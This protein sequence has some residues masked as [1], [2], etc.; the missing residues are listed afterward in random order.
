MSNLFAERSLAEI[1][2]WSQMMKEQAL[3]LRLGFTADQPK[4]IQEAVHF[5]SLFEN[6][7]EKT[8][9]LTSEADQEHIARFNTEVHQA[10]AH[11]WSFKRRVLE[12]L[13]SCTIFTH[14]YPLMVDHASRE[15][16]YFMTRLEQLNKGVLEPLPHTLINENV[17]FLRLMGDH[18]KFI[19][20]LLD[21]SE[22]GL[23]SEA[24]D[25]SYQFDQLLFQAV[26][27][28]SMRPASQTGP[29]L[30][31]L[32]HESRSATESLCDFKQT[33]KEMIVACR[34]RSNIHPLFI[35]HALREAHYF[36]S[37]LDTFEES[38]AAGPAEDIK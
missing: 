34:L 11:F 18:A 36:L 6:I 14:N 30:H 17:F 29:I 9:H 15:A 8:Y 26:D 27:L 1:R 10:T 19:T 12:L 25:F 23:L 13:L 24:S 5:Q 38:L 7:E 2:F 20:H 21:P 22:R 32:I 16:A 37:L 28:E 4:L 33:T 3:F 31:H 35:D